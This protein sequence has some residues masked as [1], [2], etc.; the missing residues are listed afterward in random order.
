MRMVRAAQ[1]HHGKSGLTQRVRESTVSMEQA[2]Q[3]RMLRY[4][5]HGGDHRMP[6]C[7]FWICMERYVRAAQHA[8]CCVRRGAMWCDAMCS[9][10]G[11]TWHALQRHAMRMVQGGG[12]G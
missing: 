9:A 10:L 3:V 1:V 2:E 4:K 11:A 8:V 6:C 5:P 7:G 12:G